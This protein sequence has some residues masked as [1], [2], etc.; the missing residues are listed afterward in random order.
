MRCLTRVLDALRHDL[1]LGYLSN[2]AVSLEEL[3]RRLAFSDARA[4]RRAFVRWT[5]TTPAEFR[6]RAADSQK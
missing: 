6:R 1:A 5:G 3:A 2:P 4:L